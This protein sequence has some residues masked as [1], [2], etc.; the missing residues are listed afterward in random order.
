MGILTNANKDEGYVSS[1][2]SYQM[3]W[4]SNN[5]TR[6]SFEK[7]EKRRRRINASSHTYRRYWDH[8]THT[9]TLLL[10]LKPFPFSLTSLETPHPK[11]KK[12]FSL[13]KTLLHSNLVSLFLWLQIRTHQPFEL[14]TASS[15]AS[16]SLFRYIFYS[17]Q[18]KWR[19][20]RL[21]L[22]R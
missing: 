6:K 3:A 7:G 22:R 9:Q 18:L 11:T 2:I 8:A 5:K 10:L 15:W 12:L 13:S 14:S 16:Q 19:L 20:F 4:H 21:L 17:I 1:I